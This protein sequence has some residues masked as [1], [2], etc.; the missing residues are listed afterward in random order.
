MTLHQNARFTCE[1]LVQDYEDNGKCTIHPFWDVMKI[2]KHSLELTAI[3]E[4]TAKRYCYHMHITFEE[5]M[6][7]D[8]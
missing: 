6:T 3:N 2:I 4:E 5:M 8:D 7:A 1:M